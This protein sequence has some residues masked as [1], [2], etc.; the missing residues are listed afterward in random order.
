MAK[1][2]RRRNRPPATDRPKRLSAIDR[3]RIR[4]LA[5]W[6]PLYL[7]PFG[8]RFLSTPAEFVRHV[9][10]IILVFV[11]FGFGLG[12]RCSSR[13]RRTIYMCLGT[14]VAWASVFVPLTVVFAIVVSVFVPS[15]VVEKVIE[16][17]SRKNNLQLVVVLALA[18]LLVGPVVRI[19]A[20]HVG[21]HLGHGIGPVLLRQPAAVERIELS[22]LD[23]SKRIE[24]HDRNA[25]A[26]LITALHATRPYEPNHEGINQ[27]WQMEVILKTGSH[28]VVHLGNGNGAS[29]ETVWIEFPDDPLFSSEYHNPKL[30]SALATIGLKLW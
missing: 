19:L 25:I 28:H 12:G 2:K 24:V 26:Q 21:R 18:T 30:R 15:L 4:V 1:K 14:I 16:I 3:E 8:W 23:E 6:L 9:A 13:P 7:L 11:L 10:I 17:I 5:R 22:R 27:P 20:V 29:P